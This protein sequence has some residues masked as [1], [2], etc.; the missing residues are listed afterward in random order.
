LCVRLSSLCLCRLLPS[1]LR[2]S[3]HRAR[4]GESRKVVFR[5]EPTGS[6]ASKNYMTRKPSSCYRLQLHSGF[7]FDDAAAVAD[8]LKALGISHV[9]CSPYLQ[10]AKGSKHGYDVV[11]QQKV[12]A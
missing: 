1:G 7:T 2:I 4:T 10:A 3:A 5:Q 6:L 8:Y 11:D 9:Y 12:N